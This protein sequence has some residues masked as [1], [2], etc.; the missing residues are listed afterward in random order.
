MRPVTWLAVTTSTAVICLGHETK[1]LILYEMNLQGNR[2][3][4]GLNVSANW[5]I[6]EIIR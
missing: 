6:I 5:I 3:S 2:A 1:L 4:K